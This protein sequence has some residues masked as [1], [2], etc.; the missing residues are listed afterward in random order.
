M[1][2]FKWPKL[3][4]YLAIPLFFNSC[5]SDASFD[6]AIEEKSKYVKLL[7]EQNKEREL[8]EQEYED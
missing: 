1:I 4:S 2:F 8:K 6:Q 7:A 5:L 3:G